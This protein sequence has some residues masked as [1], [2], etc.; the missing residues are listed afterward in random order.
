M[1]WGASIQVA[2]GQSISIVGGVGGGATVLDAKASSRDCRNLFIVDPGGTLSLKHVTVMGGYLGGSLEYGG[3]IWNNGGKVICENSTVHGNYA[4]KGGGIHNSG[5]ASV[6]ALSGTSFVV[7]K[8][9]SS[10]YGY[11]GDVYIAQGTFNLFG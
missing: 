1:T 4:A 3:G 10:S 7:N 5:D 2:K 11:G 6:L 9:S 8:A